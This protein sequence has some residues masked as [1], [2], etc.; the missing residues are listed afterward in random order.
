[1][2]CRICFILV[3]FLAVAFGAFAKQGSSE[4]ITVYPAWKKDYAK[5]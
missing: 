1:M 5:S 4:F 2:K 3:V